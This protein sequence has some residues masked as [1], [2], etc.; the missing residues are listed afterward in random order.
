MPV[1]YSRSC[2]SSTMG[3]TCN[4]SGVSYGFG[5]IFSIAM[6]VLTDYN[7][8]RMYGMTRD[9]KPATCLLPVGHS[10]QT[11]FSEANRTTMQ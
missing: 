8:S 11:T 5:G 7:W 4:P 9:R 6:Q 2:E 3:A 1:G 10:Y